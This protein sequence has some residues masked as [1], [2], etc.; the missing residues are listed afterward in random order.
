MNTNRT[1][2]KILAQLIKD[3]IFCMCR[4]NSIIELNT[5]YMQARTNLDMLL[6]TLYATKFEGKGGVIDE[7]KTDKKV[8]EK[9]D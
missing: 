3:E 9:E 4:T 1:K 8:I 6:K 7:R 2:I 5:M